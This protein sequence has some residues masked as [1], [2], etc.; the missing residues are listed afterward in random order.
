MHLPRDAVSLPPRRRRPLQLTGFS[1]PPRGS[2]PDED[3]RKPALNS[4]GFETKPPVETSVEGWGYSFCTSFLTLFL[5]V[6]F[7]HHSCISII[8]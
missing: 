5:L 6:V 2:D 3:N 4:I 1:S 8:P 7:L